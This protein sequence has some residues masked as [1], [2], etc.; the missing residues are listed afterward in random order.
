MSKLIIEKNMNG[1]LTVKND[2][3]GAVFIITLNI[4]KQ[5]I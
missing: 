5:E 2:N 1:K 4:T 3:D